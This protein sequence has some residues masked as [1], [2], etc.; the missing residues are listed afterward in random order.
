MDVC[1]V[2]G[3]AV[4][5]RGLHAA[6]FH[7]GEVK[8]EHP[9][10]GQ[11]FNQ[12]SSLALH[13]DKSHNW[14]ACPE[15][16]CVAGIHND[17]ESIARH[18][19]YHEEKRAKE[20]MKMLGGGAA[21]AP[22]EEA[23]P[24]VPEGY[25]AKGDGGCGETHEDGRTCARPYECTHEAMSR[26]YGGTM[27]D[28]D[29]EL[30]VM[31][32]Y[33]CAVEGCGAKATCKKAMRSHMALHAGEM[34]CK[35][36]ACGEA[37]RTCDARMDH[38]KKWKHYAP[39]TN[40]E[41]NPVGSLADEKRI[42]GVL[43]RAKLDAEWH[44]TVHAAGRRWYQVDFVVYFGDHIVCLEIDDG[45]GHKGRKQEAELERMEA[46]SNAMHE[47]EPAG[48]PVTFIRY[49]ADTYYTVHGKKT[50]TT[51]AKREARLLSV[52]AGARTAH[53]ERLTIVYMYYDC[54][55]DA[56]GRATPVIHGRDG[57]TELFKS[58]CGEVVY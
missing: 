32:R 52:I 41:D 56:E 13:V 21:S 10:C 15:E 35:C 53:T 47:W 25:E 34:L 2:C 14:Y 46:I 57:Y 3:E 4:S 6:E 50:T 44:T 29:M 9:G 54:V 7:K 23:T 39:V 28:A 58:V 43:K 17:E 16:G 55:T 22:E 1:D 26:G 18:V 48:R 40:P 27:Y 33:I 24:A 51:R 30:K 5:H 36:E 49:N 38:M 8:C 42:A 11:T 20:A 45:G 37:F 12:R 19:A 31:T